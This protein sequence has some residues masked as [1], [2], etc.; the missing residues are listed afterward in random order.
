MIKDFYN[1][2]PGEFRSKIKKTIKGTNEITETDNITL[3]VLK[4]QV[5]T[6]HE[7]FE[8][9]LNVDEI[10]KFESLSS[11]ELKML[12]NLTSTIEYHMTEESTLTN[13][14]TTTFPFK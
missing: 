13:Y 9:Y 12:F 10:L 14:K 2:L 3:Q 8:N 7:K 1:A 11:D 6:N 5:R 4:Q